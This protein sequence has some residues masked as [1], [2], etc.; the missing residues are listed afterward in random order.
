MSEP[1]GRQTK[2]KQMKKLMI[3][4]AAAAMIGG[5][6]AEGYD[7]TASVKTT[8]GKYGTEKTSYTVNLGKDAS[9]TFWWDAEGFANAN[10]GK[11]WLKTLTND[12]KADFAASVNFDGVDCDYNVPE[13]YKNKETWCATFKFTEVNEDCYRVAG[14]RKLKGIVLADCCD[15]WEF[16]AADFDLVDDEITVALLYRFGGVSLKKASKVEFAA[17]IGDFAADGIG[18]WALAGQGAYDVKNGYIKNISGNIVGILDN[19]DCE[20]CC[21]YD[22]DAGVFECED[23]DDVLTLWN[24]TPDGTAAYGSWS[25]KYNKKY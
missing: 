13:M 5:A 9:D 3:A 18:S 23:D 6:F 12:E 20:T 8:K 19:P 17:E 14:S 16:V 22:V 15:T 7:F 11:K 10:E 2:N 25:L 21:D 4:A 24:D 1:R